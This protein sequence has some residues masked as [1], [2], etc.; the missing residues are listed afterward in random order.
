LR[1]RARLG[2]AFASSDATRNVARADCVAN[3]RY[4]N[5]R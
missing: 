1:K 5:I 2:R 3:P 4:G